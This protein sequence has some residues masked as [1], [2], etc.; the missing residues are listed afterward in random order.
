VAESAV[1]KEKMDGEGVKVINF[2]LL[3]S[4]IAALGEQRVKED[5]PASRIVDQAIREYIERQAEKE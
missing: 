2:S 3:L 1:A 4:T 5:R